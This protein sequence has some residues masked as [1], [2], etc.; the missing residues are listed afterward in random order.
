[1]VIMTSR[2]KKNWK[3]LGR[4]WSKKK[5]E[6][7]YEDRGETSDKTEGTKGQLEKHKDKVGIEVG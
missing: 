2:P 7:S 6:K 4:H 1:M 5:K 3:G